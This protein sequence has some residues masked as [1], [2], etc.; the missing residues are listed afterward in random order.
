MV[1]LESVEDEGERRNLQQKLGKT[2]TIVDIT[3]VQVGLPTHAPRF[4]C[5]CA[6]PR[7]HG[8]GRRCG[9]VGVGR[10]AGGSRCLNS[11]SGLQMAALCSG[12]LE[13]A[14]GE[15]PPSPLE[16]SLPR[17]PALPLKRLS[18]RPCLAVQM[19]ALC[20]NVL[21]LEDG[22]G[23]P[24]LAMSTQAYNAFTEDQKRVLRW[25][26]ALF[27]WGCPRGRA[28]RADRGWQPIACAGP[29]RLIIGGQPPMCVRHT[30]CT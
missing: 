6:A 19:A 4:R 11:M 5:R 27:G 13:L 14:D 16:A 9:G 28:K 30:R 23:L 15:G 10:P 8:S 25:V 3:R 2:H 22:R 29:G 26:G 1:C 20:G 21:E 17:T 24:V 12:G 18:F 7:Q